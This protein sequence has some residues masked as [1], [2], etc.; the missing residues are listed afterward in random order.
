[1]L[2]SREKL[3]T[4]LIL[5]H[6]TLA[7]IIMFVASFLDYRL[8]TRWAHINRSIELLQKARSENVARLL[9]ELFKE[10]LEG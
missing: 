10:D 8:G 6:K 1:V 9:K 5:F 3:W 7:R 2:A 4:L